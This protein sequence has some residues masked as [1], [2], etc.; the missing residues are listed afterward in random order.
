MAGEGGLDEAV[1][2]LISDCAAQQIPVIFGLD[3]VLLGRIIINNAVTLAAVGILDFIGAEQHFNQVLEL[4]AVNRARF[5]G[6]A[7]D[8]AT[9]YNVKSI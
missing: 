5:E 6:N 9:Y 7:Y 4:V 2:T 3:M 1:A 8:F